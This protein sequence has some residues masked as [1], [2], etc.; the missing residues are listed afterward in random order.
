MA[1]P[2]RFTDDGTPLYVQ[3]ARSIKADIASGALAPGARLPSVR[4]AAETYRVN[5]NTMHRVLAELEREGIVASQR[6]IGFFVAETPDLVTR[7]R[8]DEARRAMSRLL[9]EL[10]ALGL[11][12]PEI[13]RLFHDSLGGSDS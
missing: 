5:P 9:G 12:A 13:E 2:L 6:G 1:R 7:L 3:I 11:E 10:T 4:D 8:R